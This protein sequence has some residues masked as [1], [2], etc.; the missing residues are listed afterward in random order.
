MYGGHSIWKTPFSTDISLIQY[1]LPK[2]VSCYYYQ[3]IRNFPEKLRLAT[4]LIANSKLPDKERWTVQEYDSES[5]IWFTM[6]CSSEGVQLLCLI[7]K[8][9]EASR[10]GAHDTQ[11]YM[12]FKCIMNSYLLED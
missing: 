4:N 1:R 8:G 5:V 11:K 2:G 9:Q 3:V 10:Y 12:M 6:S 7:D